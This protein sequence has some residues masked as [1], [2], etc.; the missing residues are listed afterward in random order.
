MEAYTVDD[1]LNECKEWLGTPYVHQQR[2]KKVGTD[3][4]GFVLGVLLK[5]NVPVPTAPLVYSADWYQVSTDDGM[6]R[7]GNEYLI[8]VKKPV[9]G[10]V[11][12]FTMFDNSVSKHCGFLFVESGVEFLY[13]SM[14]RYGVVKCPMTR[15]HAKR[16]SG[17][18]LV[19]GVAY[20]R[21]NV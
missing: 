12:T 19:P 7:A 13:H 21:P 18:F 3:C 2:K 17:V 20:A 16:V 10:S 11:L 9:S 6:L 15:W 8:S 5:L 4:L 1:L 14:H